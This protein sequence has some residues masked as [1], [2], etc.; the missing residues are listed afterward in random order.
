MCAACVNIVDICRDIILYYYQ[1]MHRL[2]QTLYVSLCFVLDLTQLYTTSIND[3]SHPTVRELVPWINRKTWHCGG[4]SGQQM[5]C[6][7]FN[8]NVHYICH[9]TWRTSGCWCLRCPREAPKNILQVQSY[10]EYSFRDRRGPWPGICKLPLKIAS[11]TWWHRLNNNIETFSENRVFNSL[12][13]CN[14]SQ[15]IM[16]RQ[17]AYVD[18]SR[19]CIAI[20]SKK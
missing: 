1:W 11:A 8:R 19:D 10:W 4:P 7:P 5:Q 2:S 3:V 15:N 16:H 17:T 12:K 20:F 18:V 14:F 13:K 6:G 9:P